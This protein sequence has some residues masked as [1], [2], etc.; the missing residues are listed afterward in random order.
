MAG[1]A[2]PSDVEAATKSAGIAAL[3]EQVE[4]SIPAVKE[5]KAEDARAAE[6]GTKADDA[7]PESGKTPTKT[8][9]KPR[10][11]KGRF[12]K[13]DERSVRLSEMRKVLAEQSRARKEAESE[14]AKLRAQASVQTT[15]K[16]ETP[17]VD[18]DSLIDNLTK[19]GELDEGTAKHYRGAGRKIL[20]AALASQ[21][22]SVDP[23]LLSEV[24]A[25][26]EG[27]RYRAQVGK[28]FDA[29]R[30]DKAAEGTE[31]VFDP[32]VATATLQAWNEAGG[33]MTPGAFEIAYRSVLFGTNGHK[34]NTNTAREEA[35]KAASG[36]DPS[37]AGTGTP[38]STVKQRREA[39]IAARGDTDAQTQIIW[40]LIGGDRLL[41][42]TE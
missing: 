17:K 8:D 19:N 31:D 1:E 27:Q 33:A 9:D 11:D 32:D 42:N 29:W 4:D 2:N 7:P 21:K 26:V 5:A 34:A 24:Q 37:Q 38:V 25:M 39:L 23:A 15:P 16:A 35:R 22:P 41:D 14:L 3:M 28:A 18:L 36:V 6:A 12:A 20:E 10:D 13:D 40:D 30:A